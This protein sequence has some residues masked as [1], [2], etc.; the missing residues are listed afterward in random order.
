VNATPPCVG[1]SMYPTQPIHE[2]VAAAK[3]AEEHAI[4]TL[5]IGD[6]QN[7]WRELFATLGA[8]AY[9]TSRIGIA[10]GVSNVITRHLTTVAS[11]FASLQETAPGRVIA[12]V[13]AGDSSLATIGRRPM[14]VRDLERAVGML[15][16]LMSG[17]AVAFETAAA[18]VRIT[19]ASEDTSVPIYLAASGLRMLDLAGRIADGVVLLAGADPEAIR[20]ALA[21]VARGEAAASRQVGSVRRVLW[22]PVA[23]DDDSA[24][25]RRLVRPHVARTALRPHPVALPASLADEVAELR[26]RYDFYQ[27]M[28][29]AAGH[30]ELVSAELT[31][32]FAVAG[33]PGE[34]LVKLRELCRL[35]ID[36]VALVPFAADE[37]E[38]ITIAL[39]CA[40][41]VAAT[42]A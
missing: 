24:Q 40:E 36:E 8:V 41:L 1:I 15:K 37:G 13:G 9:G 26:A 23:L 2:I 31:E 4:S 18:Q 28:S 29:T 19:F 32:R 14:R 21:Q 11:A 39:K 27:H 10:T 33:G 7:I 42:A 5:W 30:A 12:G 35:P 38:R 20:T 34:V 22:L 6:S 3:V 16:S 25:A 17:R